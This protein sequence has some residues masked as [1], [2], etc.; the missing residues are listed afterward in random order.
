MPKNNILDSQNNI[1][2]NNL[3]EEFQ[4]KIDEETLI[5]SENINI[6]FLDVIEDSR[7][8][9]DANCVWP[10][11]VIISINISKDNKDFGNFNLN[12]SID[13]VEYFDQFSIE[14]IKIDP[15]RMYMMKEIN[16]ADYIA[17]FIIKQNKST[18]NNI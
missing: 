3:D 11:Q 1:S 9:A 18:E 17:T 15:Y 13:T 7:C 6:K 8:S 10:G 5:K 4:L 16:K 12:T 2:E 14:F